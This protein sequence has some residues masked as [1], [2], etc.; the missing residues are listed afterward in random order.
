MNYA[1]IGEKLS[2]S[3]SP[4][5]HN[6]FF[7]KNNIDSNYRLVELEKNELINFCQEVKSGKFQGF[8]VTIPYKEDMAKAIQ[9][10]G[11]W[12]VRSERKIRPEEGEAWS[13]LRA[14]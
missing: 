10:H 6:N 11:R 2:H 9:A 5:I 14:P 7:K 1:L 3:Y 12:G 8:N 4:F 13:R